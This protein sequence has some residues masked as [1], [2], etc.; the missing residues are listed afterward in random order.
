MIE[1]ILLHLITD[2]T[3]GIIIWYLNKMSKKIIIPNIKGEVILRMPRFYKIIG[4]I[5]LTF[6]G[7]MVLGPFVTEK[8]DLEIVALVFSMLLLFGGVGTL[9]ILCYR[10]HYLLF[11]NY[12]VEVRSPIGKVKHIRWQD[13]SLASFDSLSGY[14]TLADRNGNK[15]KIFKQLIGLSI[16]IDALESKAKCDSKNLNLILK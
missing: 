16:F 7:I 10:N 15:L 3:I 8:P 5:S 2:C 13:I 14:L 11:D 4:Y 6:G 1:K 12:G 9:C